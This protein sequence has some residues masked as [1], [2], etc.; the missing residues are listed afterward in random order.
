[1]NVKLKLLEGEKLLGGSQNDS[2][3]LTTHRIHYKEGSSFNGYYI[4]MNLENISSIEVKTYSKY[5][6]FILSWIGVGVT[7]VSYLERE[8]LY[9]LIGAFGTVLFGLL[10]FLSR[11]KVISVCSDGSSR[12][13]IPASNLN[14]AA[15][16][17]Y[18]DRIAIAKNNRI[19]SL[20][21]PSEIH[22]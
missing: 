15:I 2:L 21:K 3:I 22:L 9:T 17:D 5:Y 7:F 4:V 14:L 16:I 13:N 8:E 20:N 12:M 1:M 18:I 19:N 10:Y 11:K 6:L